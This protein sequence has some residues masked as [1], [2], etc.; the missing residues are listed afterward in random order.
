VEPEGERRRRRSLTAN[1]QEA[2]EEEL[3][4]AEPDGECRSGLQYFS[5]DYYKSGLRWFI[6]GGT[7]TLDAQA[8]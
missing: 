4:V 7:K 3:R 2:E 6:V 1:G 5:R 8:R